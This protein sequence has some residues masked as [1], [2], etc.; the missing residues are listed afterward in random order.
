MSLVSVQHTTENK[1][2]HQIESVKNDIVLM[3]SGK[4]ISTMTIS[5]FRGRITDILNREIGLQK[6]QYQAEFD[7]VVRDA[8]AT[9]DKQRRNKNSLHTY[10]STDE[11]TRLTMSAFT[12]LRSAIESDISMLLS[13]AVLGGL[14]S[15]DILAKINGSMFDKYASQARGI[16]HVEL[17]GCYQYAYNQRVKDISARSE[18]LQTTKVGKKKQD[19]PSKEKMPLTINVWHHSG[20]G[21]VSRINH[22][23]MHNKGV[24]L[25]VKFKLPS[26][27][28]D[29]VFETTGP[30]TADLANANGGEGIGEVINC[31]CVTIPVVIWVTAAEKK[32]IIEKSEETGGYFDPRWSKF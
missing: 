29:Q 25:G 22:E 4:V 27:D 10:V 26:K 12:K 30:R 17:A 18:F 2:T 24:A 11:F 21:N 8:I 28:G 19:D 23:A 13:R 7:E 6:T 5:D 15:S 31:H 32:A 9:A 1:V 14:T 20:G 3:L 16:V